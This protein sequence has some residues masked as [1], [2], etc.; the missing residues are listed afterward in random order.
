MSYLEDEIG[1]GWLRYEHGEAELVG[2]LLAVELLRVLEQVDEGIEL[3]LANPGVGHDGV[4]LDLAQVAVLVVPS[5]SPGTI[6]T[7]QLKIGSQLISSP[8]LLP[9]PVAIFH[10]GCVLDKGYIAAALHETP[11]EPEVHKIGGK[12]QISNRYLKA[13][14]CP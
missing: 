14:V 6:S 10:D 9:F 1:I 8:P 11:I 12:I 2:D 3:A 7:E 13:P 4:G 5:I